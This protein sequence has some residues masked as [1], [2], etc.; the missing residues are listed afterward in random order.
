MN[1]NLEKTHVVCYW[2]HVRFKST[3]NIVSG[4]S[5]MLYGGMKAN[6]Y[7]KEYNTDVHI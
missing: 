5:Y 3:F 7:N 2:E 4:K 6:R 1:L